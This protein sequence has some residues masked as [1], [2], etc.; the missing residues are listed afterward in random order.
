M[1]TKKVEVTIPEDCELTV[2]ES[3]GN[4]KVSKIIKNITIDNYKEDYKR[5][6]SFEDAIKEIGTDGDNLLINLFMLISSGENTEDFTLLTSYIKLAIVV[7]ALNDAAHKARS[8]QTMVGFS[9]LF[10]IT[11]NKDKSVDK[12]KFADVLK[13]Y[14]DFYCPGIPCS[15]L[16]STKELAKYCGETFKDMWQD[17]MLAK[18]DNSQSL[19]L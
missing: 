18:S 2:D 12:F 7:K 13:T 10:D 17:Y 8:I 15:L 19:T 5:I 11:Y 16:L 3:T 14:D 6:K 9:P 4:I 1:K